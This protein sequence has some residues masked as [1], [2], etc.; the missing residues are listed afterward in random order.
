MSDNNNESNLDTSLTAIDQALTAAKRTRSKGSKVASTEAKV[1]RPRLSAEE[2]EARKTQLATDRAA[3]KVTRIAA[4]EARRAA[5]VSGKAP[6]H[7]V[8]V[9]RA[10]EKLPVLEDRGAEIFNEIT[11]NFSRAQ[12][13]A[14]A[15]HLTHFNRVMATSNAL[16]AK[17]NVGDT[18]TFVGG[19]AKYVGLTGTVE[20]VQRIR[21]YITVE[22]FKKPIYVFTSDVALLAGQAQ[23]TGTNG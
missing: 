13:A 10:A 11:T 18:V 15:Q 2:R 19:D 21:A 5:K 23:A 9:M 1:A 22:G 6:A 14:I 12:V 16:S 4:R 7:M 3:R 17:L 8:K 20:R